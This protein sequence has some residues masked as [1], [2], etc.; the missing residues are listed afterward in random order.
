MSSVWIQFR[1]QAEKKIAGRL[2]H[3]EA[4]R[5]LSVYCTGWLAK[6]AAYSLTEHQ[7]YVRFHEGDAVCGIG[8]VEHLSPPSAPEEGQPKRGRE[9]A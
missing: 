6:G 2:H 4:T 1:G 5:R 3:T 8:W 9:A 7:G